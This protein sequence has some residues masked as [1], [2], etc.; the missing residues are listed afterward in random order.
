MSSYYWYFALIGGAFVTWVVLAALFT[1]RIDYKMFRRIDCSTPEL[2]HALHSTKHTTVHNDSR[3]E[4]LTNAK[5]FY[6]AMLEAIRGAQSSI[7]M[8][9]YIF[10]NDG[11]G[12]QFIAA[13]SERAQTGVTVTLV[14][15]AIGS[16]WLGF[17]GVRRL[18]DA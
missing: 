15:D 8:E 4:I 10:L 9:C 7:N 2:L 11:I 13:M 17:S 1:P 6:P 14:V 12:K 16:M 18:R 3:F 5:H